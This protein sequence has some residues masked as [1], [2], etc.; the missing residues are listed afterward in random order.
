MNGRQEFAARLAA[1][2]L[3]LA[4]VA[5]VIFAVNHIIP[6]QRTMAVHRLECYAPGQEEPVLVEEEVAVTHAKFGG[7]NYFYIEDGIVLDSQVII[8]NL[9]CTAKATGDV[10]YW[11]LWE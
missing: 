2:A 1:V 8:T 11:P 10:A 5:A 3:A 6:K 7:F 4:V 9:S